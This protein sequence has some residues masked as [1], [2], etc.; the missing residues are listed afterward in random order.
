LNKNS[1]LREN[2]Q[3]ENK[4]LAE[5]F[6][7]ESMRLS[8][9]LTKK[10]KSEMTRLFTVIQVRDKTTT[11]LVTAKCTIHIFITEKRDVLCNMSV[12]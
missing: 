9:T 12:A 3:E 1:T 6:E 5:K 11:E 10:F 8:E 7:K 4:K 2:A